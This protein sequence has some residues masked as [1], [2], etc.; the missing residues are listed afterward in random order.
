MPGGIGYRQTPVFSPFATKAHH[1]MLRGMVKNSSIAMAACAAFLLPA[2]AA[3]GPDCLCRADGRFFQQGDLACIRTA[4]GLK[5][6]KCDMAQNVTT[7]N[8]VGDSCPLARLAPGLP[9]PVKRVEVSLGSFSTTPISDA[10]ATVAA[11]N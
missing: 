11:I 10:S 6:A 8:V 1:A 7:W 4:T 3:A 9:S 2:A 5:L